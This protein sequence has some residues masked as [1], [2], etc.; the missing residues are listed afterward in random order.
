[1]SWELMNCIESLLSPCCNAKYTP[2][3]QKSFYCD[4]L[5]HTQIHN[6]QIEPIILS[7]LL[8]WKD[9]GHF[10]CFS[11]CLVQVFRGVGQR[12]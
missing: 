12:S 5:T 6:K 3:A 11:I 2:F 9:K 4:G 7:P 8:M 10:T 1:M